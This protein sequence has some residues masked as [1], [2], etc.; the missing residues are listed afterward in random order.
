MNGGDDPT[1]NPGGDGG[2]TILPTPTPTPAP[3]PPPPL[4][5]C[6]KLGLWSLAKKD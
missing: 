1:N 3:T 5:D 2:I 6:A 4:Y